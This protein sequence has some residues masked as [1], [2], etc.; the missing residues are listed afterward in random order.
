MSRKRNLRC[1]LKKRSKRMR[2]SKWRVKRK[3][4]KKLKRMIKVTR[5]I[6]NVIVLAHRESGGGGGL[7][8]Q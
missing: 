5:R 3:D 1:Y 4:M 7:I 8:I 2:T 6:Q